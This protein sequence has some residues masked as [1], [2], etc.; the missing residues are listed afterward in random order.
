MISVYSLTTSVTETRCC[1]NGQMIHYNSYGSR[2]ALVI[3]LFQ[4]HTMVVGNEFLKQYHMV[5]QVTYTIPGFGMSNIYLL[6]VS[7]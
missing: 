4:S 6:L 2:N 1:N 3:N 5:E 7:F